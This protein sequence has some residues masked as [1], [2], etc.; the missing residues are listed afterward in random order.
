MLSTSPA[1]NLKAVLKETGLTADTLRA[2]ERRYGLPAPNRSAGGQRL[3]SQHDME[4]IKWLMTRQAEGLSISRA[5]DMWNEQLASGADPLVDSVQPVPIA[6]SAGTLDTVRNEWISAC[7]AFNETH[8][9]QISNQAFAMYPVEAV[10]TGIIQRGLTEIGDKWYRNEA[11]VQQ[12]HFA[13]ALAQRRLDALIAASP[14]PTHMQTI[15]IGCTPGERHIFAPLLLTLLL[16]R[17]GYPVVYLGADVPLL[18]FDETVQQVRPALV[19]LT[20]QQ[21]H[22]TCNLR[23]VAEYLRQSK[24]QVSYGGRIFNFLPELRNVIPAHFLGET[25]ESALENA[26]IL[27]STKVQAPAGDPDLKH[28]AEVALNFRHNR[29][30]INMYTFTETNNLGIPFE[31]MNTAVESLGDNLHSVISLGQLDALKIEFDWIRGLMQQHKVEQSTLKPFIL[32]YAGSVEK[33]LGQSGLYIS[34]WLR[35]QVN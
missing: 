12:E 5:V 30:L 34:N 2:W 18:Q 20:T 32:A 25:L 11:T 16:R 27:I 6:L 29:T 28:H 33:A 31:T 19:I 22:T 35:K 23:D 4:T 14:Q 26:E 8:A 10:C 24:T 9:E 17:R 13:S 7:L 15:L 3:Y 1:F 21:L